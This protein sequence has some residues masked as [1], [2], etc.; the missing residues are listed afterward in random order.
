MDEN[1]GRPRVL[2]DPAGVYADILVPALF[3]Q[4]PERVLE[5]AAVGRGHDVLDVGCGTGVLAMAA[6]ARVGPDGVV[7]G[8]D[9]NPAMLTVADRSSD[10]V[11]WLEGSAERLPFDDA[12]FDCVVS[13]FAIMFFT[14]RDGSIAEMSRVVRPGGR[15]AI[16]TWAS[17]DEIPGYAAFVALLRRL[18][19]TAAEAMSV[20]FAMGDHDEIRRLLTTQLD[21]V[22]V[23][24]HHGLARFDSIDAWVRTD[25][26]GPLVADAIDDDRYALILR[27]A[28]KELARFT[29]RDGRVEF[30]APAL[31]GTGTAKV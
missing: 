9:K 5:A 29:T 19:G 28:R 25:A 30:P 4:W 15:I 18:A 8:V 14:D 22:V 13:Q 20:P 6:R 3:D 12:S 27:A 16:A 10:G 11:R 21:E 26:R 7:V 2:P 23:K 31:I 1:T 17:L 24:T